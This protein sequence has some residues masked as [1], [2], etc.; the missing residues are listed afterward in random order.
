MKWYIEFPI[1]WVVLFVY[2][3]MTT[4]PYND[5]GEYQGFGYQVFHGLWYA[6]LIG[7]FSYAGFNEGRKWFRKKQKKKEQ[8]KKP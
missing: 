3:T 6:T 2:F 8:P 5:F 1:L 4:A 7:G